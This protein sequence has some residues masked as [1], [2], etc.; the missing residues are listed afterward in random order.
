MAN[1]Y[2][3]SYKTE[4]NNI[5]DTV[6]LGSVANTIEGGAVLWDA[7]ETS[8]ATAPDI[9]VRDYDKGR[10]GEY[11]FGG[12]GADLKPHIIIKG[13]ANFSTYNVDVN[14]ADGDTLYTFS[15][16]H[17]STPIYVVLKLTA[18][19]AWELA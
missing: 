18:A 10:Y 16:D 15:G 11:D 8:I 9:T 1:L 14:N 19:G 2:S 5:L 3:S 13:S 6:S 12:E 7:D 4:S 17:S